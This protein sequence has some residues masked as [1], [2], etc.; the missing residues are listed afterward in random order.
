MGSVSYEAAAKPK[1]D[2]YSSLLPA[3]NSGKIDLLDEPRSISQLCSLERRTARGGRDSIDHPPG[4]HD[5]VCNAVAGVFSMAK[6]GSYPSGLEWVSGPYDPAEAAD[7]EARAAAEFQANR[8]E[9]HVNYHSG[10]YR[11][12]ASGRRWW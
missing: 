5:D 6:R 1:S 9:H 11:A 12:L 2:L 10:F 4:G 8:F 7:A 3:I